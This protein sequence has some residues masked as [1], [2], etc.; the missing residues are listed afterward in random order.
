[1]IL[2]LGLTHIVEHMPFLPP[3]HIL[4]LILFSPK[5]GRGCFNRIN[6]FMNIIRSIY[7]VAERNTRKEEIVVIAFDLSIVRLVRYKESN[8]KF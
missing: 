1:M 7:T 8:I 3:L 5:A 4:P 6:I 2:Y